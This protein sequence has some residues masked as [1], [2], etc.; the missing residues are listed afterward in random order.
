M[1]MTPVGLN[2]IVVMYSSRKVPISLGTNILRY[3][4]RNSEFS[5]SFP[6]IVKITIRKGN[7]DMIMKNAI[8]PL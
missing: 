4:M 7:S 6:M 1:E 8:C 3:S 5:D 2:V